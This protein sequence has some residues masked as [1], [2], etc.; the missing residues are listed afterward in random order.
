MLDGGYVS[1]NVDVDVGLTPYAS[2]EPRMNELSAP[3]VEY[4]FYQILA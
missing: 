3:V 1:V 2:A 4:A